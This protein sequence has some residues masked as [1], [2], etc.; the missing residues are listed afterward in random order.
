[1]VA[2]NVRFDDGG[3]DSRLDADGWENTANP[4]RQR[5]LD[6]IAAM[7][8]DILG[9]QEV[10]ANQVS[11]L[12]AALPGYAFVGVGRDDGISGGEHM[13]VYVRSSRLTILASGHYWLSDTPEVPGTVFPCSGSR[14]MVTWLRLRDELTGRTLLFANTHW[15]NACQESRERS[16]TLMRSR[17]AQLAAGDPV[18]M[19]GDL[20]QSVDNVAVQTLLIAEP[21]GTTQL[22]DGYRAVNPA[23]SDERTFHG[24]NG[25]TQG[26]RIDYVLHDAA[27]RTTAATIV[28]TA[29]DGRYP[30]DHYP[31]TGTLQWATD[32]QGDACP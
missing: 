17:W 16:A 22:L 3:L 4:R 1:V 30:S 26:S 21:T 12:S 2:F 7:D 13:A 31:V 11:D 32:A 28:R 23:A 8:P 15:D 24:F 10:L 29:Y 19:T 14:R 25:G 6:T 27:F 9:M 18:V 20:N 5:V